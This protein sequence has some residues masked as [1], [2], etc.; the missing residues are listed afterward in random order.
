MARFFIRFTSVLLLGTAL[1]LSAGG[2]EK[3]FPGADETTPSRAQYFS[4]INNTNEGATAEQT[5]IN[6]E[7][8]KWLH[9]EYGMVLDIYAFDA[10]AIDGKGFYGSMESGRFKKQFPRGFDPIYSLAKSM[11]TRLGVWGGPDGFGDTKEEENARIDMMTRLCRDYEFALFKFDAVSGSLRQEKREAFIRMMIRCRQHSPDLILLNHRL[12]LGKGL[13]YATTSL[14]EGAET[15]IDVW[16]SN[17]TTGTHHRVGALSRKPPSN[18][19]RLVEDHGVCLSSCLDYWEDDLILQAFNRSLILAP[20]IYGNPW[21]LRDDEYPKLARI[22]NLHRRFRDILVNGIVLPKEKY[23]PFSVSRGNASIRF[24]TLRN[25]SWNPVRYTVSIGKE[26]GLS[27]KGP[28]ELRRFFPAEKWIGRFSEGEKVG[29]NVPAFRSCLLAVSSKSL[30]E[31]GVEGCKY[32][33]VRDTPGKPVRIR[34]QGEPG[35]KASIRLLPVNRRFRS[36]ELDGRTVPVLL[37]GKDLTVVFEGQK[38]KLPFHRKLGD[39]LPGPVPEDAESLYEATCFAADSNALEVRSLQRS[40]ATAIPQVQSARD[41]FF[42]QDVF[43]ERGVW[44]KNLFD[45][46]LKTSFQ[47]NR[48]FLSDIRV[49]GGALRLD[50]GRPVLLDQLVI[51][52]LD[53]HSLQP[54]KRDEAWVADVSANLKEWKR[55]VLFAGK[56]VKMNLEHAGPVRYLRFAGCPE[57]IFEI[58]GFKD[59]RPVDRSAWKASN[60][61]GRFRE[62]EKSWSGSFV[63]NEITSNSY[64]AVAVNGEH[65]EEGVYAAARL[66]GEYLGAPDRS[67]SYPSN[68]WEY[69]V[70]RADR[71]T[72]SY[73]PLKKEMEGKTIDIYVL[74]LNKSITE[75]KPEVWMTAFPVP[76]VTKELVLT[77]KKF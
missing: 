76:Y 71:N 2:V 65:G 26:L 64:L 19:A 40:G 15:Y 74:G 57:Q 12:Q 47:V 69:Y 45:G 75:I 25:L 43:V 51:H 39:L 7:F 52:I 38:R 10:G 20:E 77:D 33:V 8:F 46:N 28:F 72:T 68:T 55:I 63:L 70:S 24:I 1:S 14:L 21:L 17:R 56:T 9:D 61:L 30:N 49:R 60:L 32:G 41:A 16:M 4:W 5:L 59:G 42:N 13:P 53:E 44:D 3:V 73:I 6:L 48:R 27:G 66:D 36:A 23:G 50:F 11:G 22:Y 31:I 18:L 58:E 35:D 62:I 54:L 37:R 29:I 67:V 34:L